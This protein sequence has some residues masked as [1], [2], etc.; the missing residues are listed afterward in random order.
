MKN[1]PTSLANK[2]TILALSIFIFTMLILAIPYKNWGFKTDDFGNI[3]HAKIHSI[4]EIPNFF[5][6]GNME[7]FNHPSNS[8]TYQQAFFSGLFRPMSFIYYY[9][10]YLLFGDNP[11]GYFFVTIMFH[12]LNTVLL[13]FIL[14]LFAPLILSYT[15]A[16]FFAFHPSL[17]NWLGWVSA[18]TYYIELFVLLTLVLLLK[19][20]IDQKSPTLY[21][22]SCL[23]YATN[24]YLKEATIIVPVWLIFGLYLYLSH[25]KQCTKFQIFIQ[26]IKLSIG[27]WIVAFGYLIHRA[28]F[29][30]LN[31]NTQTLTFE[32]TIASFIARQKARLFDH[33][34]YITDI[35]GLSWM[36]GSNQLLKGAFILF[37]IGLLAVLF[38]RSSK[39]SL[40]AF[41]LVSIP[42]FSWPALLMH[43]QPRYIYLALPFFL[44]YIVAGITYFKPLKS[45]QFQYLST[46]SSLIITPFIL[47]NTLFITKRMKQRE[48]VF[49]EVTQSFKK[50]LK[51]DIIKNK[52]PRQ[53]LCFFNI[54]HHW[55]A[56]GTAQAVWLL[57]NTKTLY[58]IYQF[59]TGINYQQQDT[60]LHIPKYDQ[61]VFD[62]KPSKTGFTLEY[63]VNNHKNSIELDIDQQ[64]RKLNPLY[65]TW[66][67]QHAQFKVLKERPKLS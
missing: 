35:L 4:K 51:K 29:F 45:I 24:L 8:N 10:Q 6:E 2:K 30:P 66:D 57:S 20:S 21:V 5:T 27:Y 9:L 1:I 3:F 50:L 36:P 44:L 54:P 16:L 61:P 11:Y 19:K 25:I 62:V 28:M 58:P 41:I 52:P 49:H 15:V 32:P 56:M 31:A 13:F 63:I 23:L 64:Y 59:Q 40:L 60:Y 55:F 65:I 33:V 22:L 46:C 18:Q 34:T 12:A 67:Y 38:I 7:R 42:I 37:L 14:S 26:S 47:C 43:Y 17:W 48:Y 53:P 39:K